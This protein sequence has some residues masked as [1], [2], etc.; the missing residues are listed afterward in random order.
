MNA[1]LNAPPIAAMTTPA[2]TDITLIT[3]ITAMG[4]TEITTDLI[5]CT[6]CR[7]P[8]QDRALP[9]DGEALLSEVEAAHAFMDNP[10]ALRVRGVACMS[11]CGRSCTVAFQAAGKT[12]YVFGELTPDAE[13]AQQ[14]LACGRLHAD[15]ADGM[16]DR[17]ARPERLR[18][19]IVVRLPGCLG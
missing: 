10:A 17:N 2:V 5:V 1:L 18:N 15:S 16:L 19:G 11:A 12:S 13:T 3:D 9:P 14:V 8:G 6:T 4:T 7:R